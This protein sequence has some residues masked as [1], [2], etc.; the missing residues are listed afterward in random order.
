MKVLRGIT[1]LLMSF[2]A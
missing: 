2:A 1:F